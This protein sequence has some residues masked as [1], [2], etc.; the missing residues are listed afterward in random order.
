MIRSS[1]SSAYTRQCF[2]NFMHIIVND[3]SIPR[4][5][6]LG[7]SASCIAPTLI[8]SGELDGEN[9]QE[10][11]RKFPAAVTTTMLLATASLMA[12]L[13]AGVIGPMRD[14]EI[15]DLLPVC[16]ARLTT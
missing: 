12:S 16:L 2:S 1:Q 9:S 5:P 10:S 8:T 13:I 15:T 6:E 7:S 4:V 11:R 14:I 3:K